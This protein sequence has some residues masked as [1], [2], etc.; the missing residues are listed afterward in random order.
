MLVYLHNKN[1]REIVESSIIS[2]LNTINTSMSK[3]S[4]N[5]LR[6]GMNPIILP[7]AMGK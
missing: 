7:P 2:K 6:K 1:C 5:A 4:T 3:I